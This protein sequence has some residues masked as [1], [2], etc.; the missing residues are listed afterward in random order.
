MGNGFA[1]SAVLGKKEVMDEAQ[2]TFISS[3]F[4]TERVGFVAALKTIEKLTQ[5]R[6]WEHLS[7]VGDIIGRGWQSLGDKHGLKLHVTDFKPLI[8]FKFDYGNDNAALYTLFI[9]EM[10]KQGYLAANS[11]YV[12]YA[13]NEKI[14]N[15]Y[16]RRVDKVFK[17]I[18]DSIRTGTIKEKLVTSIRD[19]GFKRLA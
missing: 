7:R 1:I 18:I 16:L 9:Q 11:V 6:V 14:V 12:S 5:N 15:D 19:D 8:T 2:E 17:I 3:T 10:L 4:W 13:H